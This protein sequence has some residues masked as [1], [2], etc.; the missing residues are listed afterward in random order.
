MLAALDI[1]A[2]GRWLVLGANRDAGAG[3]GATAS[4][5]GSR[6]GEGSASGRG[7]PSRVNLRRSVT[8][9]GLFWSGMISILSDA[10]ELVSYWADYRLV[11][12]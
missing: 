2:C 7:S 12:G 11:S 6:A 1:D 5:R 3:V 4:G 9:N 10:V 8:T